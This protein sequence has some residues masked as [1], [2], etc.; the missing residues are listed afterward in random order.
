MQQ[1]NNLPFPITLYRANCRG[2]VNNNNYPIAT[3]PTDALSLKSELSYD[4]TFIQF[5][6]NRRSLDNFESITVIT[7]DCD[8]DHSEN[9]GDWYTVDDIHVKLNITQNLYRKIPNGH[10]QAFM[11]MMVS[12]APTQKSVKNSIA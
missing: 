6:G 12:P 4:H 7:A 10:L 9:E 3:T 11:L 5:K 2:N 8:N 1:N